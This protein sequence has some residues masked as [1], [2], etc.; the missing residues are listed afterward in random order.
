MLNTDDSRLQILSGPP[1]KNENDPALN[2]ESCRVVVLSL[3]PSVW[4]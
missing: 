1:R 4:V 3:M 2:A